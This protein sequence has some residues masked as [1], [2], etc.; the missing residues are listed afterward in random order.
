VTVAS[1]S[2]AIASGSSALGTIGEDPDGDLVLAVEFDSLNSL[3]VRG[4]LEVTGAVALDGYAIEGGDILR[5]A[6]GSATVNA[7]RQRQRVVASVEISDYDGGN[8]TPL[9]FTMLRPATGTPPV[10]SG[11]YTFTF[12]AS[13]SGCGCPSTAEITL[14][15]PPDGFAASGQGTDL[16]ANGALL[17]TF[18]T[19]GCRIS[20]HGRVQCRTTYD[21]V[22][23]AS[24]AGRCEDA[25]GACP[26]AL[27]GSLVANVSRVDGSGDFLLGGA[28]L[29]FGS[30]RW[31]AAK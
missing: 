14:E 25:F 7:D 20:P 4:P 30:G 28:P 24:A 21:A 2:G 17:G 27:S 18:A 11:I 15:V 3:L 26:L 19:G 13:P 10:F 16:D 8:G 9:T 12:P 23:P 1:G 22:D 5:Y 6:T 29:I 31:S